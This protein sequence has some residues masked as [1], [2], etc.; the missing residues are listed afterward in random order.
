MPSKLHRP[1]APETPDFWDRLEAELRRRIISDPHRPRSR[2]HGIV[3]ILRPFA[4]PALHGVMAL[5]AVLMVGAM[6]LPSRNP[7]VPI[8]ETGEPVEFTGWVPV[9]E[10]QEP[11]APVV[12]YAAVDSAPRFITFI[13]SQPGEHLPEE[14]DLSAV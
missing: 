12:F 9:V 8:V 13:E 10:V 3:R 14:Q 7:P 1:P 2:T 11:Q 4:R 6:G 5:I